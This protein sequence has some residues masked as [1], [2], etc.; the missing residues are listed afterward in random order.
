[1]SNAK[2]ILDPSAVGLSDLD[3]MDIA[4]KV[5]SML[6]SLDLSAGL[7]LDLRK[8]YLDY[9]PCSTV[10]EALLQKIASPTSKK[11][12][13]IYTVVQLEKSEHYLFLFF[14]SGQESAA[15]LTALEASVRRELNAAHC[16]V[17]IHIFSADAG[18]GE[19][20]KRIID[21]PATEVAA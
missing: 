12:I 19:T 10:M 11:V 4:A 20:A 1:M 9:G 8:C 3:E 5:V 14:R 17:R 21:I 16:S 6:E 13:E 15:D 7:I 2:P 18:A